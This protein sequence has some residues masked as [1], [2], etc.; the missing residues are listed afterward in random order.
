MAVVS[1]KL[2]HRE[3]RE[4]CIFRSHHCYLNAVF[5]FLFFFELYNNKLHNFLRGLFSRF[6]GYSSSGWRVRLDRVTLSKCPF[7]WVKMK[8]FSESSEDYRYYSKAKLLFYILRIGLARA[9]VTYPSYD[10]TLSNIS[11]DPVTI[12]QR[13]FLASLS[14]ITSFF[15]N[16]RAKLT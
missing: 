3:L 5:L 4:R 7:F 10:R 13:F 1:L 8:A 2:F 15:L 6:S 9:H 16:N 14:F 12:F 11:S